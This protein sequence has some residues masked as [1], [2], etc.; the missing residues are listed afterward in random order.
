MQTSLKRNTDSTVEIEV[1]LSHEETVPYLDRATAKFAREITIEGFR[2]GKAPIEMVR[3]RIGE[4]KIYEEALNLIID[5]VLPELLVKEKLRVVGRPQIEVKKMAPGNPIVFTLKTAIVPEFRLPDFEKIAREIL[6]TK[7]EPAVEDKE[8]D[9]AI[10]WLRRSRSTAKPAPRPA[11]KGDAVEID[12]TAKENGVILEKGSSKNHPLTIGDE[13]FV[14]GFE[15]GLIGMTAGDKKQFS[16]A[17]PADYHEKSL[18]GKTIEFDVTMN[19]VDEL[20]LPEMTDEFAKTLGKFETVA[21]VNQNIRDGLHE[22]KRLRET[23]RI[24]IEIADAIAKATEITTPQVLI[25]AEL[26]KMAEELRGHIEGM[27]LKYDDYLTHIKKTETDLRKEWAE[28]ALRRVKI[29]MVLRA[30]AEAKSLEPSDAEIAEETNRILSRYKTPGE[31]AKDLDPDAV[32]QYARGIARN[33]K[34]FEYLESP[35][36]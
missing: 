34:V 22:E 5:A 21:D 20:I 10:N 16:V 24:R 33:E 13:K 32:R 36:N 29:A 17:M 9:E 2:Q 1:E 25:D 27:N 31:A 28:D 8:I 15:D 18:A 35:E 14:P 4:M 12:F 3:Q 11:A 6:K 19:R 23:E 26:D 30:I 7:K